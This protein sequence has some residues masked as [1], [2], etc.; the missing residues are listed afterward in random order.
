MNVRILVADEREAAFFDMTGVGSAPVASGALVNELATLHDRDLES[1]RPGRGANTG[2]PGGSTAARHAMDGERSTRKHEMQ[3]FARQVA[4]TIDNARARNEF[5]RLVI[6][7][8]PRMLG[9]IR[10]SLPPASRS[11]VAAEVAK[12]LVHEDT[13]AVLAAVPRDAFFQ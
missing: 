13:D 3:Q 1:D 5:D 4:R 12:D 6:V 2:A 7:A 9:W 11:V 10:E 8:G